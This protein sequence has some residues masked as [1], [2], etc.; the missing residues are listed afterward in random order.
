MVYVDGVPTTAECFSSGITTATGVL[1]WTKID[2]PST[3][4][5]YNIKLA[6]SGIDSIA[7]IDVKLASVQIPVQK[8]T[9]KIAMVGTKFSGTTSTILNSPAFKIC[10]A[11]NYNFIS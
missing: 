5:F 7:A 3:T 1:Y 2:L 8:P 9:K 4:Q 6:L 10:L 11:S